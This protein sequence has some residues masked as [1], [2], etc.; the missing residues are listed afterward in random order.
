M[1]QLEKN[2]R[3]Q[4]QLHKINLTSLKLICPIKLSNAFCLLCKFGIKKRYACLYKLA[5]DS[6]RNRDL[7]STIE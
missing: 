4:L 5:L 6:G 3:N 1:H 7:G 2:L